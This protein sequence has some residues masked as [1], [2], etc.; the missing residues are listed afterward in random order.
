MR[1]LTAAIALLFVCGCAHVQKGA[2]TGA[3]AVVDQLFVERLSDRESFNYLK[4]WGLPAVESSLDIPQRTAF[5]QFKAHWIKAGRPDAPVFAVYAR[6]DPLTMC[7]T[8]PAKARVVKVNE[9][10]YSAT[11]KVTYKLAIDGAK[12][13]YYTGISTVTLVNRDGKWLV[14]DVSNSLYGD[15]KVKTY[16]FVG[17]LEELS[18]LID[19]HSSR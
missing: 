12:G 16:T 14:S 2:S 4:L 10:A 8:P 5:T 13:K 7:A 17:R 9:G 1:L 6:N 3:K 19:R 18:K 11:Y 15:S